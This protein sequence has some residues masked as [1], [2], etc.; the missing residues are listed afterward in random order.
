M[1]CFLQLC[2]L[3]QD[4]NFPSLY[5]VKRINSFLKNKALLYSIKKALEYTIFKVIQVIFKQY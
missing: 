3:L 2:F 1:F 4:L 5:V